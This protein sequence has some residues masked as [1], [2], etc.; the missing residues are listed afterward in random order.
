MKN[1]DVIVIGT[2][3]GMIIADEAI[4]HG[5]NQGIHIHPALSELVP[6]TFVNLEG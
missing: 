3:C 6:M 4:S 2:G 1:Y 5:L